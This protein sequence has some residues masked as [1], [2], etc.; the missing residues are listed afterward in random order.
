MTTAI[1]I[2]PHFFLGDEDVTGLLINSESSINDLASSCNSEAMQSICQQIFPA[3][4]EDN[5]LHIDLRL[6]R[7][8]A[9]VEIKHANEEIESFHSLLDYD[10]EY[11]P[12]CFG[13]NLSN[14]EG[15]RARV[16]AIDLLD[17]SI[18]AAFFTC[19]PTDRI[20]EYQDVE[21]ADH[22]HNK[23]EVALDTNLELLTLM[24][25]PETSLFIKILSFPWMSLKVIYYAIKAQ[26]SFM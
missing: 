5:T 3:D 26:I 24:E 16:L 12:K 23:R 4:L 7:W 21:S 6:T 20:E 25:D 1:N 9:T 14:I 10:L 18:R 22:Y 8:G 13:I 11:D 19:L 15:V 17:H 2:I